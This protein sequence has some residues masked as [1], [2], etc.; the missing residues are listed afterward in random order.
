MRSDVWHVC[1]QDVPLPQA[2]VLRKLQALPEPERR[3]IYKQLVVCPSPVCWHSPCWKALS[4]L[5]DVFLFFPKV[6]T[7]PDKFMQRYGKK[8]GPGEAVE[9]TKRA[10]QTF[11][12]VNAVFSYSGGRTAG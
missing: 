10:T 6:H 11:Q 4:Q 2:N 8:L 7:H 12:L 1:N 3:K 5:G 9:A